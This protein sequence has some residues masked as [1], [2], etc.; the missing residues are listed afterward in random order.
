MI[1][2][3]S[4]HHIG[5]IFQIS[6]YDIHVEQKPQLELCVPLAVKILIGNDCTRWCF[7]FKGL[8]QDGGPAKFARNL[9]SLSLRLKPISIRSNSKDSTFKCL[10]FECTGYQFQQHFLLLLQLGSSLLNILCVS[11]QECML[12]PTRREGGL[13]KAQNCR[14]IL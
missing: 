12:I 3:S 14:R 1:K 4:L 5:C 10:T 7:N 6:L 9:L 8:S 2:T 13:E 11:L